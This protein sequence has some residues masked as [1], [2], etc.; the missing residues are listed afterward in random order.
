MR[1]W[2]RLWLERRLRGYRRGM[3]EGT[4]RVAPVPRPPSLD[5]WSGMWV[6][7]VRNQVVAADHTSH[8][9]AVRLRNMDHRRRQH[10][11]VEYVRPTSDSY[12]VGVG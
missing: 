8:G 9:L 1:E 2:V 7:V 10:A 3:T 6:A 5:R 12:I 4:R 11:I